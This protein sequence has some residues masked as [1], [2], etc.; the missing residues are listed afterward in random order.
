ME[1]LKQITRAVPPKTV[2]T[3][4]AALIAIS[5]T[6]YSFTIYKRLSLT[7]RSLI[8]T[9]ETVADSFRTS[10]TIRNF[11]NPHGHVACEDSRSITLSASAGSKVPSE[12]VLLSKFVNGF[13]GGRVFSLERIGLQLLNRQIVALD[14]MLSLP[15]YL[16]SMHLF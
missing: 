11:V 14:G 12:E 8:T 7:N 16:C 1:T 9:T 2:L 6:A 15:F 3:A 5:G 13:F 4:T 10:A